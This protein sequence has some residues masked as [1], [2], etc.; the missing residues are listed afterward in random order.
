MSEYQYYEFQAIDQPLTARQMAAVRQYSSRAEITPRSFVNEYHWGNFRGDVRR[1]LRDYYDMFVYVANWGTHRA[2][3]RL[4]LAYVDADA[5][6]AYAAPPVVKISA[7]GKFAL[8]DVSSDVDD[9]DIEEFSTHWMASLAPLRAEV[10]SGDYRP[11]YLAW[12]G[13]VQADEVPESKRE[14]PVPPGLADLTS[15]QDALADFLRVDRSMISAAAEASPALESEHEAILSWIEPLS[16]E[17]KNALLARMLE[18]D[19]SVCMELRSRFKSSRRSARNPGRNSRRTV[20]SLLKL[21]EQVRT[22][23]ARPR[24]PTPAKS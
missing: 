8:V 17:T 22:S 23:R 2:A 6:K 7:G 15:A 11:L 12:L 14:P 21:A 19:S 4:P 18:G 10:L 5:L 20:G 24:G 16:P 13:G 1:F 3:F 9:P